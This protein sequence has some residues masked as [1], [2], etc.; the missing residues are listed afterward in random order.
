MSVVNQR[1]TGGGAIPLPD[2]ENRNVLVMGLGLH[3]GGLGVTRFLLRHGARVTVT[4]LRT[5]EDL[6][7]TLHALEGEPVCYV[8]GEH[9]LQDFAQTE[10][11]VRN[12]GVPLD[13]PY[14][15]ESRRRGIPIEMEMT[16]FFA[17]C[18]G[19]ILGVT[20]TKGKSTTTALL[21]HLLERRYPD[22]VVA[23]N[24][25]VSALEALPRIGPETP[26]VLELSSWQLEGLGERGF[27]PHVAVVTNLSPDHLNRYSSWEA[28]VAAKQLIY[29]GQG[30]GDTL[31]LNADD[32]VVRRFAGDAPSRLAWFGLA[33]H[34]NGQALRTVDQTVLPTGAGA[35]LLAQDE[36]VW[37][38]PDGATTAVCP[39]RDIPLPGRHNLANV[40]A[41]TA[42]AHLFGV[43]LTGIAAGIASFRGLAG[44]LETVRVLDGVSYI[45]DTTSTAPAAAVAALRA[46]EGPLLLI[47]GGA[48]KDLDYDEMA[49]V[50]AKRA[51]AILLL[52]GT[53]T[54]KIEHGLRQAGAGERIVGRFTDLEAAVRQARTMARPGETVLLSPGCASFGMFRH[55]FER[56]Q[57]FQEAVLALKENTAFT[58]AK[59]IV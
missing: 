19:T 38:D 18:P 3:G 10:L 45:N 20:G 33:S 39:V 58:E 48:D 54:D 25:R 16:L 30:R 21:G 31:V 53:A 37:V 50:A 6:A 56:G 2:L 29:R 36:I 40:L 51:R 57:R 7:P 28:Y 5:A 1:R 11:V 35:A 26:V 59:T 43:S 42:A 13:S 49:T 34:R 9:R 8:L 22:T 4:D 23:G 44:R 17:H 55:E 46:L 47:A 27:A 15:A 12:P 24:L 32:P 41:A 14:L 52:E